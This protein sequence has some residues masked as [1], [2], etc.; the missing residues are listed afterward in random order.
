M[1]FTTASGTVYETDGD[2][3]RRVPSGDGDMRR[4]SDWLQLLAPLTIIEG[5]PALMVLEPLGEG[6]AT[7]RETS[8]VVSISE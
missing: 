1:R 2:R 8:R 7:F 5:E 4:D 3:V 6:D